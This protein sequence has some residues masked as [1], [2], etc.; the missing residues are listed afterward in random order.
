MSE[1]NWNC[2]SATCN[3]CRSRWI[4]HRAFAKRQSLEHTTRFA[5]ASSQNDPAN[6]LVVERAIRRRRGRAA[7][8]SPNLQPMR[9]SRAR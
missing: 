8:R 1:D 5:H 9:F 3:G 2:G 6:L 4:G 7:H